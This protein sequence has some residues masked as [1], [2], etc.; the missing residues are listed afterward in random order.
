MAKTKLSILLIKENIPRGQ[1]LKDEA[2]SMN[3]PDGNILY[4]KVL[5]ERSPKWVKNFFGENIPDDE[6]FK[7]K[8]TSAVILYEIAMPENTSRIFAVCFGYGRSL[9][10]SNVLERRFGLLVT[11]NAFKPDLLRSIDINTLDLIPLNSRVQSSNLASI[12]NFNIDV[13]KDLLKSVAGISEHDN[14]EGLLSGTD[15]LSLSTEN[16]YDDMSEI[17]RSCYE[18]YK[19]DQYKDNFEWVDQIQAIKDK[20]LIECLDN[21]MLAQLNAE[22]SEHIWLS[23]PEI[24]DWNASECFKFNSD[25]TYSDID[26]STLKKEYGKRFDTVAELKGLHIKCVNANDV[27]IKK[28]TVYRC[29]YTDISYEGEQYLLNDG[30]WL[31]VDSQ[32]AYKINNNYKAMDVC[33]LVLPDYQSGKEEKEYNESVSNSNPEKFYLMDRKLINYGSGKIEFC[34]L[35]TSDRQLIHVKKYNGSSVLSHLF[36]QGLVSAENFLDNEF[37]KLVNEKMTDVFSIPVVT[38]DFSPNNFEVV[39]VIIGTSIEEDGRPHIPFFS[40]VSLNAV[41]KRLQRLK[42]RVSIKGINITQ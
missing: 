1:I 8:S 25:E 33:H 13:E 22:H 10:N 20:E 27:P 24:M 6:P 11:L 41:V 4:Y 14:V 16:K 3:L 36:M 23:L 18:L 15:S 7:S 29:I 19:S 37:R 30:K 34:D 9:L 42:Y 40:K 32:F 21:E 31:K 28:W 2:L 38:D 17:L 26:I 35:Y 39:Y 12:D 5:P